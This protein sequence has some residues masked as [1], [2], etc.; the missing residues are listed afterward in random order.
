MYIHYISALAGA[1]KTYAMLQEA[2]ALALNGENV[3]FLQPT[4]ELCNQSLRDLKGFPPV[5]Y[6]VIHGD[7][8]EGPV[9]ELSKFSIEGFPSGGIAFSTHEAFLRTKFFAGKVPW[10]LIIDEEIKPIIPFQSQVAQTHHHITKYVNLQSMEGVYRRGF[11]TSDTELRALAEGRIGDDAVSEKLGPLAN[12]LL[13]SHWDTF[14]HG[15]QFQKLVSGSGRAMTTFSIL[16]PSLVKGFTSVTIAGAFFE[17]TLLY[18][19]WSKQ[20]VK[21]V[22]SPLQGGLEDSQHENS[23]LITIY[24]AIDDDWSSTLRKKENGRIFNEIVKSIKKGTQQGGKGLLWAANECVPDTLFQPENRLPHSPHGLNNYQHFDDVAFL[25]ARLPTPAQFKFLEEQG[26]ASEEVRTWSYYHSIYQAVLRGSIRDPKNR[27]PK[28]I[29]VV[30]R[31]AREWLRKPFPKAICGRLKSSIGNAPLKGKPGRKGTGATGA[32]R[33]AACR[34]RA[35]VADQ[36][37]AK[38]RIPGLVPTVLGIADNECN[39]KTLLGENV[40]LQ[41]FGSVWPERRSKKLVG[42]V[43][44]ETESEFIEQLK[45]CLDNAIPDKHD[46]LLISPSLF[47]PTLHPTKV[48]GLENVAYTRGLFFDFEDGDLTFDRFAEINSELE[49]YGWNSFNSTKQKPRFRVYIPT[50]TVSSAEEYRTISRE[51]VARVVDAGYPNKK[52]DD[53]LP[54]LKAHGIDLGKLHAASM[55][56]LPCKASDPEAIF[57]KAYEGEGR[58]SLVPDEWLEK[59]RLREAQKPK[60]ASSAP[61]PSKRVNPT[62]VKAAIARWRGASQR[63]GVGHNEFFMLAFNLAKSG[64]NEAQIRE[65]LSEE[66]RYARNPEERRG[67]IE[68]AV[69]SLRRYGRFAM[70]VG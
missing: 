62:K 8:V 17:E 33:T 48:R 25:S 34:Q 1:G 63:A 18:K 70:P 46:N 20:G 61:R 37:D 49:M 16:K 56:Y 15:E 65:V 26:I 53:P 21:F 35:W 57:F 30:D 69:N 13:S 24:D 42:N 27:N 50:C 6:K 60:P 58:K 68:E 9:G 47:D 4:K 14:F 51:I 52:H 41:F 45:E 3:L 32:E 22:K 23:S 19:L 5:D 55:F 29:F 11:V 59:A 10:L 2:H 66:W 36:E 38:R 39:G 40:T 12:C 44:L 67:E 28:R 7:T 43:W 31:G 64:M 54:G